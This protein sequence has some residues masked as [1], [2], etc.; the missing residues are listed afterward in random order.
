VFT[1]YINEAFNEIYTATNNKWNT[2]V[3]RSLE[4]SLTKRTSRVQALASY[5]RQ[6]RN[7]D[8]T[9]QPN[10]PA[11][12]IQP[13][14]FANDTGIGSSTGTSSATFDSNSLSGYHMTQAVTASAQWQDH[15]ARIALAFTGPWA[16]LFSTNYTFQSGAWSGPIIT[17]VP[18]PDPAFGP[19]AVRLSN[20]RLVSN[21]LATTLRFAYPTRGEGQLRTPNMHAWNLRA[22]RRI[23]IGPAKLDASLD[24][25]N[26]TNNGA[27]LGFE[28][29]ANQ[30]FNPFFGRTTY[31]QSPRSA[32]IVVRA[33]F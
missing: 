6:W 13:D 25:F 1:G 5:V 20:G 19:P 4:F 23:E 29:L 16:L 18:A 14:A 3:Y 9:W 26:V 30:T 24:V 31:R 15:V 22:G 2:P 12:F 32:Q 11:S 8:G 33:S 7:I 27:D 17:R 28:F 21:P 10:D